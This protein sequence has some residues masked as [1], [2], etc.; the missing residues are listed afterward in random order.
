MVSTMTL[1]S[2]SDVNQAMSE[3]FRVLKL[4]G[5]I[6]FLEH[7]ISPDA[8]V[9]RRQRRLNWLQ[10]MFADG[11]TL[12]LDMPKLIATRPFS[13]VEIDNFYMEKTPRTHDYMFR[14]EAIK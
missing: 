7:G 11:C 1:C 3:L 10:R 4:G 2:I 9:A 12:T 14:G 13:S 5:L 6:L 8:K